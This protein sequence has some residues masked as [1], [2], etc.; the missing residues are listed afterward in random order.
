MAAG[1]YN[2]TIEQGA[3]FTRQFRYKD[4]NGDPID[5]V[6]GHGARMEI[7]DKIGGTRVTG[8]FFSTTGDGIN[9]TDTNLITLTISSA[10]TA[11]FNFT[12]AVYDIEIFTSTTVT[13]LLQ[14][15]IKL[16]KEVTT[17]DS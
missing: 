13:R 12:T 16:S 4:A 17:S 3:T 14:G 11:A 15:K 7:K 5:L 9:I 8:G 6:T 2:F 10:T 1:I